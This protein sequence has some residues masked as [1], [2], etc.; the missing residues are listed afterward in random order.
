MKD[1]KLYKIAGLSYIGIFFAAMFGNFFVLDSLKND[2]IDMVVNNMTLVS[3]G[4]I[5]FLVAAVLD[6]IVAWVLKD[7]YAKHP[8]TTPS[9]YFRLIHAALMGMAVYAIVTMRGLTG[10]ESILSQI[11]IFDTIWL[12]GLFFFGVHLLMLS[13]ILRGVVPKWITYALLAAGVMYMIDTTAHFVMSNY[14]SYADTFLALVA[15]PS[16]LGEM[17]LSVWLLLKSRK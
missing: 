9:T 6:T 15:I 14:D 13:N 3:W 1:K 16:I 8:L 10:E 17:A 5:A 2:P 12:I 4:A 7:L 11:E